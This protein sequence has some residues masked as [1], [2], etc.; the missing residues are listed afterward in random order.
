LPTS[1]IA[2]HLSEAEFANL[3]LIPLPLYRN[4]DFSCFFSASSAPE[5][6]PRKAKEAVANNLKV[7][8]PDGGGFKFPTWSKAPFNDVKGATNSGFSE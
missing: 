7:E 6:A 2:E 1:S 3:G 5:L 4:H 8:D